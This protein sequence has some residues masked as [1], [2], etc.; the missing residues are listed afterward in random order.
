VTAAVAVAATDTM[1]VA[2]VTRVATTMAHAISTV[3][4]DALEWRVTCGRLLAWSLPH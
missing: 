4:V 3:G 2:A 1:M